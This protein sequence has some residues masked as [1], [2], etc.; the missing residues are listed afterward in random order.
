[1]CCNSSNS[2]W[3]PFWC[4]QTPIF[5]NMFC[6]W[7]CRVYIISIGSNY[8]CQLLMIKQPDIKL[9][10]LRVLILETRAHE[11]R[12]LNGQ[13]TWLYTPVVCK[14][15]S[16]MSPQWVV[17][18]LSCCETKVSKTMLGCYIEF[19]CVQRWDNWMAPF[20]MEHLSDLADGAMPGF[21][22]SEG[23]TNNTEEPRSCSRDTHIWLHFA[24][25]HVVGCRVSYDLDTLTHLQHRP[26]I[27]TARVDIWTRRLC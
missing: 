17:K 18:C 10:S 9:M 21:Q 20:L 15:L 2:Q 6:A 27:N 24:L 8:L 22:S 26:M 7:K 3:S 16:S 11:R 13:W 4:T 12:C 5:S 23:F 25:I 1:M 14:P 19:N